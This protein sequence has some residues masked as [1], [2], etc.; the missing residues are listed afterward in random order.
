MTQTSTATETGT[1]TWGFDDNGNGWCLNCKGTAQI[2]CP[3]SGRVDADGW[4][5]DCDAAP[6]TRHGKAS[7]DCGC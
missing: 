5:L 7:C 3:R 2:P 1:A 6:G 4:C